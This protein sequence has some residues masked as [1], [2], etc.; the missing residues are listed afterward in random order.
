MTISRSEAEVFANPIRTFLWKYAPTGQDAMMAWDAHADAILKAMEAGKVALPALL[1]LYSHPVL[2]ARIV[3]EVLSSQLAEEEKRVPLILDHSLF[4]KVQDP[5]QIAAIEA[6]YRS[7]Y[8]IIRDFV[9]RSSGVFAPDGKTSEALFQQSLSD[10]RSW[11]DRSPLD[12]AYF[13]EQVIKPA[14]ALF[15]GQPCD[16]KRLEIAIARSRACC[17]YITSHLLAIKG[18]RD[19]E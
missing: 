7:L 10:L 16:T 4:R 13:R 6:K 19:R 11:N 5:I 8:R 2:L 14:E 18:V 9:E 17:A 15:D 12:E 3:Y 1:L